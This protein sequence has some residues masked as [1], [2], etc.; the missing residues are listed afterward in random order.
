MTATPEDL[1]RI[2][3]LADVDIETLT[4]IH[5]QCE[6]YMLEPGTQVGRAGDPATAMTLILD[7]ELHYRRPEDQRTNISWR[8]KRGDIGGKLAYSRM[9]HYPGDGWAMTKVW[10]LLF[11]EEKFPELGIRSPLVMQRLVGEMIDRVR[12]VTR[13]DEQ[14][15]RLASLGKLSAG[16]AHEL[17][18]PASAAL[19]AAY[20]MQA[21]VLAITDFNLKLDGFDLACYK[22]GLIA[23]F[24]QKAVA[25]ICDLTPMDP[26][27][28]ADLQ[29]AIEARLRAAGASKAGEA[30]VALAE[31]QVPVFEVEQIAQL[32]D[33]QS[34]EVAMM[35]AA[36]MVR[37]RYL[38]HEV[39][40]SARRIADL[41][42]AIKEYSY[43][44]QTPL[45]HVDIQPGI[46]NTLT[47]L[48]HK[49]KRGV[50]VVRDYAVD[51]PRVTALGTEL[52]QVWTNLIDNAIDAMDGKGT[53]TI[54][55]A[56]EPVIN[57]NKIR[58]EIHDTG[59]GIPEDVGRHIFEPFYTTKDVGKGTGLGLDVVRRIV[60]RHQ[61]MIGFETEPG[62]TVFEVRLPISGTLVAGL[63]GIK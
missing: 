26:L 42:K 30:A 14:N 10:F 22:R 25:K 9:T 13:I 55:T 63:S 24:E 16:L 23:A 4:W 27:D 50:K 54:R 47:I 2:R 49:L 31:A 45:Q 28:Q 32:L 61:G 12:E 57:P 59:C 40:A 34:L 35:R 48:N 60:E 38:A 39:E 11:P 46:E 3:V 8:M 56:P 19:R 1:R 37:L 15:E 18:N 7:G 17:N 6:E 29:D 51:L 43:M 44:D 21:C 5:A 53:L 33:G 52:N 58:V 36:T 41:V 62:H 20:S